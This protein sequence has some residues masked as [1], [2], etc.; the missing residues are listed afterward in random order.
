MRGSPSTTS[1]SF[2]NALMLFFAFA[3]ATF[4]SW[5]LSSFAPRLRAERGMVVNVE[6]RVPELEVAHTANRR[7]ASR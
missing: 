3:F 4:R 1:V 6:A 5:R 2:A 7:I